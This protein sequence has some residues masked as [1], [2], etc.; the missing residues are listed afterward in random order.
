ME[1]YGNALDEPV[2]NADPSQN[3]LKE[4]REECTASL[5]NIEINTLESPHCLLNS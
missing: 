1:A 3:Q 5:S 2:T 4:F